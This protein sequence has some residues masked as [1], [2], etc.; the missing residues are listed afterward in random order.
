MSTHKCKKE[1]SPPLEIRAKVQKKFVVVCKKCLMKH[2]GQTLKQVSKPKTILE[3]PTSLK[4]ITREKS[5]HCG[6]GSH[7]FYLNL[8][9]FNVSL[10]FVKIQ[11]VIVNRSQ[12]ISRIF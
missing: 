10:S 3:H 4:P 8:Q 9:H 12:S 6:I 1:K 5:Q 2:G 7:L 11:L